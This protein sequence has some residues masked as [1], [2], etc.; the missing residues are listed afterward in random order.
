MASLFAPSIPAKQRRAPISVCE[1]CGRPLSDPISIRMRIGP[2]CRKALNIP[3]P[4][5]LIDALG[6]NA[7]ERIE[8]ITEKFRRDELA[9]DRR[10]GEFELTEIAGDN[11]YP[12][13][14]EF[15]RLDDGYPVIVL[16]ERGDA[17]LVAPENRQDI[18]IFVPA[19]VAEMYPDADSISR[20]VPAIVIAS[21]LP[22]PTAPRIYYQVTFERRSY[23][24]CGEL[25]ARWSLAPR[26]WVHDV[27]GAARK[28]QAAS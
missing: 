27:T 12:V 3:V 15:F 16:T 5:E 6:E 7:I 22:H 2:E 11:V 17:K 19:L 9:S 8:V 18:C 1:K 10:I 24:R 20:E 26:Q 28:W 23:V 4:Q 21:H 14:A 13:T 25:T